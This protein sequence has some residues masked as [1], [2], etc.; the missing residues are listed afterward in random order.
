MEKLE[1]GCIGEHLGHS[2]S[3]EIHTLLGGYRYRLCELAPGEVES[4]L[5]VHDFRGVN[6]T[7]PYKQAVMPFLDEIDRAAR[8][9][10]AVNTILCR[11][12]R[13][14]G[15]NTDFYGMQ[16]LLKRAGI[17]PQGRFAAVLGTG[18]TSLTAC[19]VLRAMG[20]A[21][22]V[23]VSR[24]PA[25]S[26]VTGTETVSYG[27]LL[28]RR[29][30]IEL[31]VNTT[32]VGMYP[33]DEGLPVDPA[34]FPRLRGIADAVYHPLRT[35][36]VCRGLEQGIPSAGGLY[37]LVAQAAQAAALFLDRPD[38]VQATNRV[39]RTIRDRKEN[40]VLI[41][42]PGS[43]KS[44]LG[45]QLARKTGKA[46]VDSDEIFTARIG[47]APAVY[48]TTHGENAFRVEEAAVLRE[49]SAGNGFVIATGG[50]AVVR[51]ENVQALRRN[52]RLVW[53]DR[54][55][56][57]IQPTMDRPLTCDREALERVYREREPLYRNAATL[58][59]AVSGTPAETA[60]RLLASLRDTGETEE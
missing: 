6:V 1:Y 35:N 49:L 41:G 14:I 54:P 10:G 51:Q 8:E 52:G 23:R 45:K 44:T 15:Y 60:D 40:I 2:Y 33:H 48:I 34:E 24:T 55:L 3:A 26:R 57:D 59:V 39:F 50:G 36:L 7:I 43:G 28:R 20:A 25:E 32:P 27:E 18:G 5:R 29:A 12:G 31:I 17:V 22:I 46:F 30:E 21:G 9:I 16:M 58:H 56:C 37:M 47:V 11:N 38:M 19:A 42:M 13:L 53:L 4:F